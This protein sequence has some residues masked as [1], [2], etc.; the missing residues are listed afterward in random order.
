MR[1]LLSRIRHSFH[2][3]RV[4]CWNIL[5]E[6]GR[7]FWA[8]VKLSCTWNL[9]LRHLYKKHGLPKRLVVS[10]TSYP[11]RYSTLVHTLRSLLLQNVK[12][13]HTILWIAHG[14]YASLPHTVLELQSFGLE[15]RKTED[16][17]SYKK[18]VPSL[19][20]FPDAYICTADDDIYYWPS[21]LEEL[22]DG[23]RS[24]SHMIACHRWHEIGY[25]SAKSL[26]PYMEWG[27]DIKERRTSER[28]FP[29]GVG[30]VL[31]PPGILAHSNSDLQAGLKLAPRGDDIWL[32]WIGRRNGA[33]Y[34]AVGRWHDLVSWRGSQL[35]ALW[36]ENMSGENDRQIRNIIDKYGYPGDEK[37][38][39]S[40]KKSANG[41]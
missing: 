36:R 39:R 34:K 6:H 23:L 4:H 3:R 16:I 27:L 30:G 25:N 9:N 33:G 41:G 13:D 11:K 1:R 28:M 40:E 21:W 5:R 15:I 8:Q 14:D 31:Y 26:K 20:A 24:E 18:I 37:S 32:Y 12:A 10:L 2:W 22:V 38:T 35:N 7:P 19:A 17:G 29:T